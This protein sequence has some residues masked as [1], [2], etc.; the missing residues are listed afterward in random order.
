MLKKYQVVNGKWNTPNLN[1]KTNA[2]KFDLFI[3]MHRQPIMVVIREKKDLSIHNY[4]FKNNE[5]TEL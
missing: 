3:N 5:G 2:E 1:M 4:K